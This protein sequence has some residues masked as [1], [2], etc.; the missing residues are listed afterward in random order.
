MRAASPRRR[1]RAAWSRAAAPP[2][3]RPS[4]CGAPRPTRPGAPGGRCGATQAAPR[5]RPSAVAFSDA[6]SAARSG[7]SNCSR[8]RRPSSKARSRSSPV[9]RATLTSTGSTIAFKRITNPTASSVAPTNS[10]P[11]ARPVN[12]ASSDAVTAAPSDAACTRAPARPNGIP[13]GSGA[14]GAPAHDASEAW[15]TSARMSMPSTPMSSREIEP[16]PEIADRLLAA[17]HHLD[18]GGSLE[19]RR[20][21]LLAHRGARHRQPLEQR[22]GAEQVQVGRVEVALVDETLAASVGLGPAILAAGDP[23]VVKLGDALGAL[24][25]LDHAIVQHHH[26]QEG[27]RRHRQPAA[28][29][30]SRLEHQPPEHRRRPEH[31]QPPPP[32][33][34]FPRR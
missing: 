30:A 3:C 13:R 27:G 9:L 1:A 6:R 32:D 26:R 17:A 28:L 25:R 8:S 34:R 10:R 4:G 16:R 23:V 5:P 15:F 7:V 21:C 2:G 18:G 19:P 14:A 12:Q 22:S 33:R 24:A 31:Q 20:Q 29:H 11:L